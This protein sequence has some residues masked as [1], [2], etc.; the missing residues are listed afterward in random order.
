MKIAKIRSTKAWQSQALLA[1]GLAL[2]F[3]SPLTLCAQVPIACGQ[4]ITSTIDLPGEVDTYTFGGVAGQVI[5]VSGASADTNL[6][7]RV[8]VYSPTGQ[9]L[10]TNVCDRATP[11]ITLPSTGNYTIMVHDSDYVDTGSYGL[12]LS[13]VTGQCGTQIGCGQTI[14]NSILSAGEIHTYTFVGVAGQ[15][16]VLNAY[17]AAP[18]LCVRAAV[19]SPSGQLLGTNLCDKPTGTIVLPTTGTYTVLI[20]DRIYENTGAYWLSLSF[21]TG[22]C[23]TQ[24]GC[25]QTVT[26]SFLS[27]GET[28]TYIFAGGAG[29]VVVVSTFSS[30]P[31]LCVRVSVYSPSGQL[32]GTN[33]CDKPTGTIV[34]PVT[35]TYTILVHDRLYEYTGAYGMSLSFVT[36]QCGTQIECGQTVTNTIDFQGET[37]TYIFSAQAGQVIVISA[38]GTYSP[39]SP[40]LCAAV[41]VYAPNGNWIGGMSCNG[42]STNI[43]LPVTGTYT[44]RVHDG[45]Y[46]DTGPYGLSLSFVTGQCGTQIGCGQTITNAIDSPGETDT[47]TFSG[48]AGQ[49]VVVSAYGTYTPDSPYLCA[50]VDVHSPSGNYIGGVNCNGSSAAIFLPETGT[51]TIRVHDG[52]YQDTGPYG[53]S[54]S[55][56]TGQ[57]GTQIGC[58]QT[59]T[60]TIGMRAETH[61]YTF[62]GFAGQTVIVSAYSPEPDLCVRARVYSPTGQL[63]ATNVCDK[64]TGSITLPSTGTYTILLHDSNYQDPGAYTVSLLCLGPF[65]A[66]TITA[67]NSVPVLTYWGV[68]GTRNTLEYT[69]NISSGAN[70]WWPLWSGVLPSSPYHVVDWGWT[71]TPQKFYRAVQLP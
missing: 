44:I 16:V 32:L 47:Y 71:N 18:E 22:Q 61:I 68:P 45:N 67:S 14:T 10:G 51:Y 19:Y 56:V 24:I 65:P 13:F 33:L 59:V 7:I 62:A 21:V 53:L 8:K 52:N 57:C 34:L 70:Q 31:N 63:L 40:Y 25:G 69:T 27:A 49:I 37:D 2:V 11:P 12:S 1:V 6:C 41:D 5:V 58:G 35:G 39:N 46:E 17:A 64:P 30:D 50:A 54:L 43:V 36:G 3:A 66:L 20:H 9:L 4:T 23:G 60:N 48:V 28:H 15:A 29:Q 55:F 26:N 42:A 38:F